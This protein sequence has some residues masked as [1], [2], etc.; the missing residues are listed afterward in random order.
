MEEDMIF[1]VYGFLLVAIPLGLIA[2]WAIATR[3]KRQK[4]YDEYDEEYNR[5]IRAK[6]KFFEKKSGE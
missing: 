5:Y 4:R 3:L 1:A 6:R 2:I